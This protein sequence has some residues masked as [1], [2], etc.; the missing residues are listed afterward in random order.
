MTYAVDILSIAVAVL[1]VLLYAAFRYQKHLTTSFDF[2]V[3]IRIRAE[4][5]VTW[6]D[7]WK[8]LDIDTLW[9]QFSHDAFDKYRVK[10]Q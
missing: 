1:G 9:K 2:W 8:H 10:A 5:G 4:M 7:C 3:R 6:Y